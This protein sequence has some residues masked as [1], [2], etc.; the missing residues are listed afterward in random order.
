MANTPSYDFVMLDD[1]IQ[2]IALLVHVDDIRVSFR[3]H[4]TGRWMQSCREWHADDFF[5][6][7]K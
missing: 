6:P 2:L 4:V 5:D 3:V 7:T 1:H